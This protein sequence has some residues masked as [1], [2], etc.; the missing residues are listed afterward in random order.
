MSTIHSDIASSG[1]EAR[2]RERARYFTGRPCKRGHISERYSFGGCV[3][4]DNERKRAWIGQNRK[5]FNKRMRINHS[6]R[7]LRNPLKQLYVGARRRAHD[8]GI[9]FSIQ[10]SDLSLPERC[11]C[12][13]KRIVITTKRWSP[14]TASLDRVDS[15]KGYI[16]GNVA[17]ICWHC[18]ML[19]KDGTAAEH[20]TIAAYIDAFLSG[21]ST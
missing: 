18:N 12:C 8:N 15:S 19:K 3:E 5:L 16:P 10:E 14:D 9:E 13:G 20:R 1:S 6:E 4:C 17:V 21:Q 11:P 7:R 2:T